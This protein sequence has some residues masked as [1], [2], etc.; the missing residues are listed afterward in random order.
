MLPSKTFI[1]FT[2]ANAFPDVLVV[3]SYLTGAFTLSHWRGAPKLPGLHDD[4]STGICLNALKAGI[5][6]L[7][8]RYLTNNHFDVDGF[9][10]IW[11]LMYPELALEYEQ[12]LRAAAILGD[13]R[14][15]VGGPKVADQALKLVAWINE[16]ERRRFYRLFGAMDQHENEA[17][18]CLPKYDYFLPR[19]ADVLLNP[20]RYEA[21]WG[22]EYER[23]K[24]DRKRLRQGESQVRLLAPL[25]LM[26]VQ[27][28]EPLHYYALFGQS[29]TADMVLS[30]YGGQRY[31]LEY[32]YTTWVDTAHRTSFPRMH[33]RPLAK[34][35]NELE[36]G[37][38]QWLADSIM[39]TGPILRLETDR[40]SKSAR[41]DH[42]YR[43]HIPPSS[44]AP[45][46]MQQEVIAYFAQAYQ[47]LSPR[48]RWSW[49]EVRAVQ[50]QGQGEG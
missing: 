25:R 47:N 19:F 37:Q 33:L 27:T 42:P 8:F 49:E 40:M 34:R 43:R 46:T 9:L 28:P 35:L 10:G 2:T 23:V 5:E 24:G 11:S 12:V 26:I 21:S 20:Y 29:H 38:G 50:R 16:E 41:F 31:E 32:K 44:L 1:P 36:Q 18:A 4:T 14:E 45:E 15:R 7:K 30:M 22:P 6:E 3:D 13:F 39:D 48:T 17:R